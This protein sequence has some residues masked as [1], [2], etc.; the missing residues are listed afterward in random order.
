MYY[1]AEQTERALAQVERRHQGHGH[2]GLMPFLIGLITGWYLR[3]RS[4]G[5]IVG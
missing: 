3:H 4:A 2:P 1:D 5:Q